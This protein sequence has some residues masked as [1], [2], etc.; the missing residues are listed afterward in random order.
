MTFSSAFRAHSFDVYKADFWQV[1]EKVI[2]S[3]KN[4]VSAAQYA[5]YII[6]IT[7]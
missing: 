2:F 5:H 3:A 1:Y 4:A 7:D 6:H